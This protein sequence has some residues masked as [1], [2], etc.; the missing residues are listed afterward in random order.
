MKLSLDT[1]KD[2]LNWLGRSADGNRRTKKGR[3]PATQVKHPG[4]IGPI[5]EAYLTAGKVIAAA[6]CGTAVAL[7][8]GGR[9]AY[10]RLSRPVTKRRIKLG[11]VASALLVAIFAAGYGIGSGQVLRTLNHWWGW[12]AITGAGNPDS[13]PSNPYQTA[14]TRPLEP[15]SLPS[16]PQA[17]G[18]ETSSA[19]GSTANSPD[20]RQMISPLNG[21]MKAPYGFAYARAFADYRLHPG[22]DLA[23]PAGTEVRA[24]LAGRVK[25]VTSTPEQAYRLVIDHGG[26]YET[27]YAHLEEVRVAAGD[28]VSRGQVL[29]TIGDPGSGEADMG[30]H[31][32]FELRH[33]GEPEDPLTYLKGL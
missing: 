4:V 29:G 12:P 33:R 19:T 10:V 20:L 13:S 1:V 7:V 9:R 30:P 24:A 23:A 26:N 18:Q 28:L 22:I 2:K 6:A 3:R 17:P 15:G 21:E 14:T 16:G 11:L 31:L 8:R 32:H 27:V 25:Q 5:L